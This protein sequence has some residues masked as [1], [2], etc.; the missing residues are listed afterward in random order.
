MDVAQGWGGE[1]PMLAGV[2]HDGGSCACGG[3]A[4]MRAR[5]DTARARAGMR[6]EGRTMAA[7]CERVHGTLAR[8][9]CVVV[10]HHA[11]SRWGG[12]EA[13]AEGRGIRG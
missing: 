11:A 6:W 4:R 13:C 12:D 5:T 2:G 7:A 8:G 3:G 10:M 9:A 1:A